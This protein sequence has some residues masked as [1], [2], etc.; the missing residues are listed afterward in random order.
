LQWIAENLGAETHVA[1]MNQ[2]F[3]AHLAVSSEDLGRKIDDKE[4]D[5]AEEALEEFGL[6]NGWVQD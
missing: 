1:L 2:Y 3:P 5:E 6:D 4:Y